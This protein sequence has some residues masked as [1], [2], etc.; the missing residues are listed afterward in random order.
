MNAIIALFSNANAASGALAF[1]RASERRSE[2]RER[3]SR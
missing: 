1:A 2:R 3:R